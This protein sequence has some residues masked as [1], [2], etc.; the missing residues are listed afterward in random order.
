MRWSSSGRYIA[1]SDDSARV[2]TKR[3]EVKAK[4][5]WAVFPVLDVRVSEPVQQFLFSQDE[6]YLM[7]STASTDQ[8]YDLPAKQQAWCKQWNA[9]QPR[10]WIQHPTDST[11]LV[12]VDPQMLKCYHW[13]TMTAHTTLVMQPWPCSDESDSGTDKDRSK[14]TNSLWHTP[15]GAIARKCVMSYTFRSSS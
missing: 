10:R 12:W 13:S 5:K 9:K 3:L 14:R 2:I 7:I 8:I 1:T 4:G 6:Q 11:M 15:H